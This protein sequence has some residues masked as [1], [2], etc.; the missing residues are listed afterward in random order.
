MKNAVKNAPEI[1]TDPF[2]LIFLGGGGP[3]AT[4]FLCANK[5]FMCVVWVLNEYLE[6]LF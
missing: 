1:V 6:E 3:V 2:L 4:V 5:D